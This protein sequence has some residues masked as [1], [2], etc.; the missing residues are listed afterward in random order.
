[1]CQISKI[2]L[3]RRDCA[4]LKNRK[5]SWLVSK[6][7]AAIF[8]SYIKARTSVESYVLSQI[9]KSLCHYFFKFYDFSTLTADYARLRGQRIL[10]IVSKRRAVVPE[11]WIEAGVTPVSRF[12]DILVSRNLLSKSKS[13]EIWKNHGT[14]FF[15]FWAY[16]WFDW[17]SSFN[18][19][20]KNRGPTFWHYPRHSTIS[21]SR[22]ISSQNP[23]CANFAHR[24]PR[25]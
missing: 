10:K 25:G 17:C 15:E 22:A 13:R 7:R 14:N 2:W 1:M 21:Q 9:K 11:S 6:G 3:M 18:V 16:V 5:M 4:R 12:Y 8:L 19:W 24:E 23:K 20:Q